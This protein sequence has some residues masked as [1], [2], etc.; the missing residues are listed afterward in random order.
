M[1]LVL[2][3]A[4]IAAGQA[5]DRGPENSVFLRVELN[6]IYKTPAPVF[7]RLER[8]HDRM[9][10]CVEMFG[11]V[12]VFGAIAAAHVPTFQAQ[13]QMDPVVA[14][15]ETFFAAVCV[16]LDRFHQRQVFAI[17]FHF[18]NPFPEY[19]F[20]RLIS[21]VLTIRTKAGQVKSN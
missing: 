7:A 11:G 3:L 5:V 6:L 8:F 4:I 12:F 15:F 1:R 20:N 13:P 19:K 16:G 17:F 10:G 21:L 14:H 9:L 2:V 18:F